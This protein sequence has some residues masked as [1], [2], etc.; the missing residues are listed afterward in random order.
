MIA[1]FE[2]GDHRLCHIEP[3][4]E[5]PLRLAGLVS[6]GGQQL[7]TLGSDSRTVR[8]KDLDRVAHLTSHNC[9]VSKIAKF[10]PAALTMLRHSGPNCGRRGARKVIVKVNAP[11]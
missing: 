11:V 4:S 9:Y 3:L 8:T 5:L 10:V 6:Q 7:R 2:P 1:S